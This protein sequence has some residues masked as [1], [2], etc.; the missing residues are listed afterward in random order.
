MG[1]ANRKE[2]KHSP[3]YDKIQAGENL[4]AG[5]PTIAQAVKG[6]YNEVHDCNWSGGC[7]K[8]TNGKPVG[9]FTAL[10]WK[11]AKEFGCGI[12]PNGWRGYPLYVCNY[13]GD[14]AM[15]CNTP[16]MGGCYTKNVKAS[17]TELAAITELASSSEIKQWVTQTNK[18]ARPSTTRCT[19]ATGLVDVRSPQTASR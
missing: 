16:N 3:S 13:R 6:W 8:S 9:H 10:V 18:P 2:F 7:Q 5:Y 4:A 11:G 17:T 1:W 12:S 15:N 19:M 14:K